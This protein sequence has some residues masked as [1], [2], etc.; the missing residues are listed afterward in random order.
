MPHLFLLIT[1]LLFPVGNAIQ[2]F[3]TAIDTYLVIPEAQ[4]AAR[5]FDYDKAITLIEDAID[6]TQAQNDSHPEWVSTLYMELGNHIMLIY[7]WDQALDAYDSAIIS[8]PGN[9]EAFFRRGI[10]LYT[11]VDRENAQWN[12]EQYVEMEPNGTF[13]T[14]TQSYLDSIT[15]EIQALDSSPN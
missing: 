6:S 4:I 7:E 3:V 9:A 13:Y 15:T 12:F 11:M 8:N 10:L 1:S 14:I 2:P 5:S